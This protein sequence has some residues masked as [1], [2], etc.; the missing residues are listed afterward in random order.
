MKKNKKD[1]FMEILGG[2]IVGYMLS[3]TV[4]RHARTMKSWT[5]IL[6]ALIAVLQ[7][8]YVLYKLFTI[9]FPIK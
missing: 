2:L 7:V 4:G 1:E 5:I 9:E 3:L 8:S 6:L